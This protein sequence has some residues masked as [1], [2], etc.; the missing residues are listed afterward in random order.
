MDDLFEARVANDDLL[1]PHGCRFEHRHR[2]LFDSKI[3]NR[4]ENPF[5]S[6]A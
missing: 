3:T 5:L 2:D 4:V 1:P 6:G